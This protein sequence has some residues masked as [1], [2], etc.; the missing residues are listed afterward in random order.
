MIEWKLSCR[1][2]TVTGMISDGPLSTYGSPGFKRLC[3]MSDNHAMNI[4]FLVGLTDYLGFV[5]VGDHSAQKAYDAFYI[6]VTAEAASGR[7]HGNRQ[8]E[9]MEWDQ[10]IEGFES[11]L[12]YLE[13]EIEITGDFEFDMSERKIVMLLKEGMSKKMWIAVEK[14][15]EEKKVLWKSLDLAEAKKV[16]T[17]A[18]KDKAIKDT[19]FKQ[20]RSFGTKRSGDRGSGQSGSGGSNGS[21]APVAG[22]EGEAVKEAANNGSGGGTVKK[23]HSYSCRFDRVGKCKNGADCLFQ[24]ES[25]RE[26]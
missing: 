16:C 15:L 26:T 11:K 3:V 22:A 23:K 7:P 5:E 10:Y 17:E 12:E 14:V 21:G 6:D 20:F 8:P 4:V 13:D 18:K 9:D 25:D 2:G 19:N 1:E 24:H